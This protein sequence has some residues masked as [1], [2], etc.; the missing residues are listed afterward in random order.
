MEEHQVTAD[1]VS[2]PLPEPFFV[3]ATQNPSEQIGTFPLPESQ[4]D[5]FLMRIEIGYPDAAAER[6]L[7][8][9]GG[10][11]Q[12]ISSLVSDITIQELDLLR[13]AVDNVIVSEA[14][15]DYVQAIV[16]A[17]R[18]PDLFHHGLSPR[19]ALGLLSAAKAWAF[20]SGH[21]GV[22]PEDIQAV[23]PGVVDH[24]LITKH[25][26]RTGDKASTYL[27]H[28]VAIP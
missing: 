21:K 3:V 4:L 10:T 8:E 19:A 25:K 12:T 26:E 5:R 18:E 6:R 11:R 1:G 9:H 27:Q 15:F 22:L 24:R 2:H 13:E 23:L 16:K 7:L 28:E 14:L 20:L 17:S